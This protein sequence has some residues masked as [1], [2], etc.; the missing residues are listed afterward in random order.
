M[1]DLAYFIEEMNET[2]YA[3][4]GRKPDWITVGGSYPGALSAWFKTLYPNHAVGA[5]SS[6]AVINAIE[7]FS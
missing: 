5:W 7:D 2:F 3:Q 6:S 4:I 1:A